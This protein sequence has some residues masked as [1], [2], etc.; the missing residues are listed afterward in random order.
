[1]KKL[2]I[3][4]VCMLSVSSFAQDLKFGHINTQDLIGV[5]PEFQSAQKELE[6]TRLMYV[7]E[8]QKLETEFQSKYTA[9]SQEA[10]KLDPAIRASR[11]A[12]VEKMYENMQNFQQT[13][14]DN[15]QKKQMELMI[16]ITEKVKKIV[17]Q[18]GEEMKLIYIFDMQEGT[19]ILYHSAQSVDVLPAVKKKLG[20]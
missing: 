16:P 13:A 6:D 12:E 10:E 5:M 14:Q 11:Q 17:A 9:L 7:T 3:A 15:L 4:V 20:L 2:L 1:M 8:M 18:V 19:P